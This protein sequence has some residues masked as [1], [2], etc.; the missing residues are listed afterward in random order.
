VRAVGSI[1]RFSDADN[2]IESCE[3]VYIFPRFV[4]NT[5]DD[6]WGETDSATPPSG[7]PAYPSKVSGWTSVPK[8][9]RGIDIFD[10]EVELKGISGA[11]A[12]FE[13][14]GNLKV[15]PWLAPGEDT[16]NLVTDQNSRF[17]KEQL[18]ARYQQASVNL[19]GSSPAGFTSKIGW[20][21]RAPTGESAQTNTIQAQFQVRFQG[22]NLD[23]IIPGAGGL[24]FDGTFDDDDE[25]NSFTTF[26][27]FVNVDEGDAFPCSN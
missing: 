25:E 21:V 17:Y 18:D 22:Y 1:G 11:R 9:R 13:S 2:L 26:T 10:I 12:I 14:Q 19:P 6:W 20:L 4:N 16:Q 27:Q 3:L 23:K 5:N 15:L 8:W 7:E 24:F